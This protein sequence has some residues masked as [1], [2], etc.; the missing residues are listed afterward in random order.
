MES[1]IIASSYITKQLLS[2]GIPHEIIVTIIEY[3]FQE[4]VKLYDNFKNTM[5]TYGISYG[6][7]DYVFDVTV[8]CCYCYKRSQQGSD[9]LCVR[10]HT[11]ICEQCS[12]PVGV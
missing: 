2:V 3:V 11:P 12:I 6:R 8:I 4:E 5:R 10:C 1:Q 7:D 9:F